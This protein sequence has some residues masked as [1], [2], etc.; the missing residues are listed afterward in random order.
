MTG[1][2]TVEAL[3]LHGAKDLRLVSEKHQVKHNAKLRSNLYRRRDNRLLCTT[4]TSR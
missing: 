2:E 3:V 1:T 4:A